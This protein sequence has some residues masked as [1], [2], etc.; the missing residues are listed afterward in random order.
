[1]VATDRIRT[2]PVLLTDNARTVLERRYLLR[3]AGGEVIET[4]EQLFARVARAIA[5]VEA[6]EAARDAWGQRFFDA[7]ADLRFLPNSPTLMNAGTG[8]GTLAACFVLPVEDTLES[9]MATADAA[10][11]VQKFGGGTGF[12]FSRL[13][14]VGEPIATTHGR[15]CGPVSVLRHYDDVSRLVTQGGK[16]DG[17]NMGILRYDHPDIRE[18]IHAKDDGVT[19]TRFNISIGV[20]DAFMEAAARGGAITLRDPRDGS[21]R[22][23]VDASALLEEIARSA[24]QT[25][26]PGLIFLDTINRTNPTPALGDIEATNPCG[27]VPLLPWEACTLGSLNLARFWHGE[28]AAALVS[29]AE[30]AADFDAHFDWDALR[31]TAR[32]GVRFLD[33]VVEA[34]V[35]PVPQIAEAVRGNRKVGLGVMGFADLLIAAGVPYESDEALALAS[36]LAEVI[37]QAADEASAALGEEKGPFPNW[38]RSVYGPSEGQPGGPRYRNATRTCIAPTGTIAIIAGASS[39]IEPLF[40]LAHY[41]RMGD[42]TVLPEV[43]EAFRMALRAAGS[44]ASPPGPLSPAGGEGEQEAENP[45]LALSQSKGERT[46]GAFEALFD[47]LAHGALLDGRPEVPAPLRRRFATSHEIA[48]AAHVRMQAAF[49]AHTDLAVSKTVNLPRQATAEEVREVYTLA[50]SLGCKGVTVYRDGSRAMQVLAHEPPAAGVGVPSQGSWAPEARLE[51]YRRHLAD[52]RRS[53]THKFR[54]GEQEGYL[55]VG[56]FEDGAPGE[57]F[58]KM[59]KEGSTVSGLTD[60][61]ALLTSIALQYGVSLEK[62]A[63]KLE[64]TRFEPYGITANPDIPF[65]TSILDYVFRWLRLHFGVDA[66]AEEGP[67]GGAAD[68]SAAR[69]TSR[70]AVAPSLSGLTCPDC[71]QQLEYLERCLTCRACG[72]TKCS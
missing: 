26:D 12:A 32:L 41:R 67:D 56:L 16:R 8:Q 58:L 66:R 37:G 19:A 14:G 11:M 44:E 52:E 7:M 3:D 27:E 21:P 68:S 17:A 34:N 18:F 43:S 2:R 23:T 15:A 57:V 1:M 33:N 54:V 39:G 51:P 50:H 49:Q 4:P 22:G 71:G 61:V 35:F 59:A 53:V 60:A 40:S 55:T 70:P 6:D 72:Y 30:A 46:D 20:D 31:E 65:A 29:P 63:A 28:P 38:E 42:G 10:A 36:R 9:I 13:R 48:A 62:L 45:P 47:D 5:E 69:A 64:Q 24:W 25:G